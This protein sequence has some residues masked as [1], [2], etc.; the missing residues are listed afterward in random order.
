MVDGMRLFPLLLVVACGSGVDRPATDDTDDTDGSGQACGG[1][2]TLVFAPQLAS[3]DGQM[4]DGDDVPYGIPP[5]GGAPY[6]PFQVV[7]RGPTSGDD[8]PVAWASATDLDGGAVIGT[9]HLDPDPGTPVRSWVCSNVGAFSGWWYAGEVHLRFWDVALEALEGRRVRFEL[10]ITLPGGA[11]TTA[12][13]D[14]VL[15]AHPGDTD[16]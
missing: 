13:A 6:A 8:P 3:P 9:D 1:S 11:L 5:Q 16:G 12:T 15:R 7:V 4:H 14:G 2:P 10:R